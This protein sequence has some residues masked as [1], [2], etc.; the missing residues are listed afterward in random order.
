M[1]GAR[2]ARFLATGALNTA[3]GYGLYALFVALG[4]PYLPALATATV[5]GFAE[6]AGLRLRQVTKSFFGYAVFGSLCE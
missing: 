3:F 4:M 2:V 1:D 6:F 5:L